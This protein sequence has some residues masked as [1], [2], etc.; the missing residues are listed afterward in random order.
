MPAV[1]ELAERVT[2]AKVPNSAAYAIGK[3]FMSISPNTGMGSR[4]IQ[5]LTGLLRDRPDGW[6]DRGW[7]AEIGVALDA[8]SSRLT[9]EHG[10]ESD[11]WAWGTI[12]PLT[13]EH[14]MSAAG[15]LGK[16]FNLG[17]FPWGGSAHTINNGAV[18]LTAPLTNP[19]GIASMRI[20]MDVG[21]WDEASFVLPGG[22]SGNPT[23]AHYDD[24]IE[25]FLAADLVPLPWTERAV[26]QATVARLELRPTV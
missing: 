10:P 1:V 16:A 6:F 13:L 12:R 14:V 8:V 18:D 22:Q 25:P 5:H 24:M 15:P 19:Y 2:K 21:N 23:S 4:R 11:D 17:P 26:R 9:Q 20:V 7:S 3:G